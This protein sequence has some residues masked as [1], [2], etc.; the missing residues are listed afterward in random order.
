MSSNRLDRFRQY[1]AR[2]DASAGPGEAVTDGYYVA[3]PGRSVADD[4]GARLELKPSSSHIVLGGVGSGKTTQLVVACERLNRIEDTRA[5]YIDVSEHCDLQHVDAGDIYRLL[6]GEFARL[7]RDAVQQGQVLNREA[8]DALDYARGR[9]EGRLVQSSWS[10]AD[11]E[12]WYKKLQSALDALAAELATHK[13][14]VIIV[15]DSLDRLTDMKQFAALVTTG[16]PMLQQHGFGVAL[17]GPLATLYGTARSLLDRVDRY[18]Y[19][20][21]MDTQAQSSH[22]FLLRVLRARIPE[23]VCPDPCCLR[24]VEYSGGVLRDLIALTQSAVE[25]AYVHG[26]DAVTPEQVEAVADAFGRKHLLGLDADDLAVLQKVRTSG[27]FVPTT[28]EHLALLHTRR[29]LEYRNGRVRYVV[30][31]TITALLEQLAAP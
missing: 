15:L 22:D 16:L 30:H 9:L 28:D 19:V 12:F 2:L 7:G 26:T 23:D 29:V 5:V 24:L 20:P 14:H 11:Y 21:W 18:Y 27:S 6:A 17:T 10:D 31:P 3:P 8:L 25:E 1:M 4:L 13:P